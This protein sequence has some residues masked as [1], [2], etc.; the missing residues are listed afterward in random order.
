MI[1]NFAKPRVVIV[2]DRPEEAWPMAEAFSKLDISTAWYRGTGKEDFPAEPL[3][4]VRLLI[5]DLVL[6]PPAFD[7]NLAAG[8]VINTI[9]PTFISGPF[10]LVLWTGHSDDRQAFEDAL[11]K[12]N[13]GLEENKKVLPLTVFELQKSQ[14][15]TGNESFDSKAILEEVSDKLS[16]LAPFDILLRWEASC[17]EAASASAAGVSAL[18][19]GLAE[20][21]KSRWNDKMWRLLDWLV[22]AS[23]GKDPVKKRGSEKYIGALY[24][25]LAIIHEDSVRSLVF[26]KG[27]S[28]VQTAPMPFVVE[29]DPARAAFNSVLLSASAE[30][31]DIPGAVLSM[32]SAKYDYLPFVAEPENKQFRRFSS[33]FF[34]P[35]YTKRK[36]QIL[37]L[38]E[39]VCVEMS[40]A[41]D[42]AQQNR[43]RLRFVPGMLVPDELEDFILE[44]ADYLKKIG[45]VLFQGKIFFLIVESRHFFSASVGVRLP[46]PLFRLR[47][48]VLVD[49][50]AW[51]GG[52]LSRPGHLSL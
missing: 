9:A 48:H 51:L 21:D 24:E 17:T 18:G 20:A 40:P 15:D 12:Y 36:K 25:S 50:Q 38:C 5:L 43:R 10:A 42:F 32:R 44:K 4:G 26:S 47:S 28:L 19:L 35:S 34:G 7:A 3:R 22:Q 23:G 6:N 16:K 11:K 2:D 29:E 8:A 46:S 30:S 14:F 37:S 13:S 49:I 45:P 33:S 1:Q 39:P 41:C 52:H 31:A 27:N